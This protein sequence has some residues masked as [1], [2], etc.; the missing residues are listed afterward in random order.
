MKLSRFI[1]VFAF[2]AVTMPLT[3]GAQTSTAVTLAEARKAIQAG[4]VEWG[5]A[6]VAIDKSTFEKMLAP[7]L[8]IQL[9]DRKLT[10]QEFIDVISSLPPGAALTRFDASV[11]TVEPKGDDW[12]A[13][14]LEKIEA[15]R[16]NASGKT[17]KSYAAWVTRDGWR[18]VGDKWIILY[19]EEVG[20]EKWADTPPVTNW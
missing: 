9:S 12:V 6:R 4:N 2:L 14:I 5:K 20:K 8:Y 16:K 10:R 19:S 15:E 13:I 1:L 11:L 7:D 17:E 18:K 3:L